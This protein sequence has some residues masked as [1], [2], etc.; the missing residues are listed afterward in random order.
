MTAQNSTH[1]GTLYDGHNTRWNIFTAISEVHGPEENQT[2]VQFTKK[3]KSLIT[4]END[5]CPTNALVLAQPPCFQR[6][7]NYNFRIIKINFPYTCVVYSALTGTTANDS[8]KV[9]V[10]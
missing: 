6:R 2:S 4:V 8:E 9:K 5:T 10:I 3:A 7:I 1:A